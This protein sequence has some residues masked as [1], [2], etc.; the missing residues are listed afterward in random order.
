MSVLP[1]GWRLCGE[2]GS[3]RSRAKKA[4]PIGIDVIGH[5]VSLLQNRALPAC[6][7]DSFGIKF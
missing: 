2:G 5:L 4:S 6:R 1:E 3:H 7:R